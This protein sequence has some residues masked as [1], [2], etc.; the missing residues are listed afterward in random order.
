MSHICPYPGLRPFTEEESIYFKGRD[1]HILQIIAQLEQKKFL[2]LTGA[3]GD[4][5]SSL[6]YAGVIPNARA[7][8]FK[9]KFNNWVVADFRPERN[10]LEQLAYSVA[11]HLEL[12]AQKTEKELSFGFS[13]LVNLYKSSKFHLDIEGEEYKNADEKGKK[14]L[15]R[16]S[17]NLLILADQ[18]EELFTNP[19]NYSK[20]VPSK[21]AQI[22]VN[23]LIETAKM[24]LEQN[25]P[26][27]IICTM[28]SDYI[29]QCASFRGLPEMIGFSQFFVPRLKRKEIHQVIEDPA[30]LSGNKISNRLIETLINEMS[31][32]F[33]QL[34]I[35]QHT[36]NAL[37]DIADHGNEEMDLVHLAMI[38]GINP[39]ALQT[40]DKQKV[41]NWLVTRPEFYKQYYTNFSL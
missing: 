19:E 34:P 15:R 6:V 20:G 16:K 24:A 14:A 38:A 1:T 27:Y 25:L 9:A 35:L 40:D 13:S 33:D 22:V 3:S 18:F 11:K 8:F 29:G 31:E 7:G 17:A 23:I 32:G 5:K 12:D 2:M 36:L 41:K 30:L 39:E 26:I 21:E 37:W 28:R 10:P 4:G